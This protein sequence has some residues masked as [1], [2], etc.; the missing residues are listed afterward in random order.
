MQEPAGLI[1]L[2]WADSV[3]GGNYIANVFDR[4]TVL[5]LGPNKL[6]G[7]GNG[8]AFGTGDDLIRQF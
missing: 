4:P 5:S 8:S 6:P 3:S 7:D 1:Q 2:N